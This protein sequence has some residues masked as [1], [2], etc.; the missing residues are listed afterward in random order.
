[1]F[2]ISIYKIGDYLH[3]LRKF[4]HK[5][6]ISKDRDV[7]SYSIKIDLLTYLSAPKFII[8]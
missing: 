5:Q 1:M 4:L 8:P 3:T 7:I 6:E 2:K